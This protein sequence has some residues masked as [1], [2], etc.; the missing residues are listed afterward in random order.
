MEIRHQSARQAPCHGIGVF[1]T[2]VD[3]ITDCAGP[4]AV[5]NDRFHRVAPTLMTIRTVTA[6]EPG[7]ARG[8]VHRTW[9]LAVV[10]QV[11]RYPA[12]WVLCP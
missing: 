5:R 9:S 11:G 3:H 1:S 8:K 7:P 10:T 6:S 12:R 4:G 2:D